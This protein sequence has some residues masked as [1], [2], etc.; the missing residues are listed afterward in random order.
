MRAVQLTDYGSVDNFRMADIPMPMP[1][2]GEVRI[3]VE[4]AGLRWGDIMARHGDPVRRFTPPFEWVPGQEAT[5][6]IDVLGADVTGLQVGDRVF[7]STLGGAYAEYAVA[8][9]ERVM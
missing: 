6:R 1:K 5:G 4:F 3:K 9:A 8:P 2:A 7:A